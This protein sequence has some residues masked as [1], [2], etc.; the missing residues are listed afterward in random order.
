MP[1]VLWMGWTQMRG[2]TAGVINRGVVEYWVHGPQP[3]LEWVPYIHPPG[4]SV[5]MN[6][7]DGA[8]HL[9]GATPAQVVLGTAILARVATVVLCVGALHRRLGGAAALTGGALLAFSPHQARP[10]EHYPLSALLGTVALLALLRL[11]DEPG[12]KALLAAAVAVFVAVGLHLS[13]W[14]VVGG[15]VAAAFFTLA[16][17]RKL[18]VLTTAATI[19]PFLL[20]TW[21][22]LYNVIRTGTGRDDLE[23]MTEGVMTLEWTNPL[24]LGAT[25]LWLLPPLARAVP[26]GLPLA[27]GAWLFTA[28]TLWLQSAQL[29]DGQPYPY[30]LHYFE[31]TDTPLA[32]AAAFA[33]HGLRGLRRGRAWR[34]GV[35]TLALALVASQAVALALGQQYIWISEVWF[36]SMG[37]PWGSGL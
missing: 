27:A 36:W 22:G 17:R 9:L 25:A 13:N 37:L 35:A 2:L 10:F 34:V 11:F 19:G 5:F 1:F 12:R 24:L 4:Y 28:V 18:A 31:L 8:A 20:T 14:F 6:A 7:V 26:L 32:L 33:I 15:F 16:D 29:A 23:D 30:G 3:W 21:P